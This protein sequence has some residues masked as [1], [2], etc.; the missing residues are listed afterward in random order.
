MLED[1]ILEKSISTPD[2]QIIFNRSSNITHALVR[3]VMC[4]CV[5]LL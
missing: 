4:N 2:E 3:I 5:N 1:Q